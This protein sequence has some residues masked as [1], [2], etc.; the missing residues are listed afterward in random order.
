M[1]IFPNNKLEWLNTVLILLMVWVAVTPFC[2]VALWIY[3]GVSAHLASKILVVI[4]FLSFLVLAIAFCIFL[5]A[6]MRIVMT[7]LCFIFAAMALLW[8]LV[9]LF[10]DGFLPSQV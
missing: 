2:F 5:D 4:C 9:L 7:I 10:L 8:I 6:R 1:H 3:F